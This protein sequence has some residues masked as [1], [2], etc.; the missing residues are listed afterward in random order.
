MSRYQKIG[1]VLLFLCTLFY[2][3]FSLLKISTTFEPDFSIF[4]SSAKDVL[5]GISPY[6]DKAL[7]TA[8]NYPLATTIFFIPLALLTFTTA[9]IVFSFLNFASLF[10]AVYLSVRLVVKKVRVYYFLFVLSLAL[11]AFPTKFSLG[12]GQANIITFT[13]LLTGI[14]Y[15]RNKKQ[16]SS[17][18]FFIIAFL[19]KP[20]LA[21][22]S[23]VFLFEKKWRYFFILFFFITSSILFIPVIANQ[24][25]ANSIFLQLISH[26]TFLGREVYYNQGLLGFISRITPIISA[27]IIFN[28]MGTLIILFIVLKKV[29]SLSFVQKVSL[30]LTAL[31]LIDPLSWQHHFVFLLLPFLV[32]W[33]AVQKKNKLAYYFLFVCAYLLVMWNIKNPQIFTHF[34]SPLLLSHQFYAALI[35]FYLQLKPVYNTK[36]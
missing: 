27:R 14:Y 9:Q 23:L 36:Q 2:S 11:L 32:V 22:I 25:Q 8:F 24:L 31:L 4:Y 33:Q 34:T 12:M 20:V 21:F 7:F 19:F 26:Q 35:L 28:S 10:I 1:I 29:K 6:H 15:L 16:K 3:L 13:F 17:L 18:I 5:S 30:L